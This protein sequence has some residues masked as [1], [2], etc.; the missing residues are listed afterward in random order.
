MTPLKVL[1]PTDFSV[2]AEYAWILV[3]KLAK[4]LPMEVH[5]LHVLNMPET[6]TLSADGKVETCGEIDVRFV[7]SQKAIAERKLEETRQMTGQEVRTHLRFGKATETILSFAESQHFE[8]IAMGTKGSWGVK[9]KISGSATQMVARKSLIPVLSLMCDRSELEIKNL[10][11]VHDFTDPNP[12]EM[13]LLRKVKEAFQP[14]LH[15]LQIQK[16]PGEAQTAAIQNAM[17]RFASL[18]QLGEVETH[19]LHDKD[20]ENGVIHF[21]QMHEMDVICIGT[22][23]KGGLLHSS[24][25]EKLINHMFKPIISFHLN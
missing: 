24:V 7:E 10:L 2:Q 18:H 17:S 21:N 25:T 3:S 4:K 20:V 8:L 6:V 19:I 5:F 16:Q 12:Q 9:E 14:A 23:G 13:A 11:L 22:H 15:L 1:I